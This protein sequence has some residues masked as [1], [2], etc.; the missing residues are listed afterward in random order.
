MAS[1]KAAT[2]ETGEGQKFAR[3]GDPGQIGPQ[4]IEDERAEHDQECERQKRE[5]ADQ[6]KPERLKPQEPPRPA[7]HQSIGAVEP[8]PERLDGARGE[9]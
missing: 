9:L 6:D 1:M 2:A 8:D 5:R 7:L 3:G 4:R